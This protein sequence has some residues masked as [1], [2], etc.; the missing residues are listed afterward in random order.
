MAGTR[1]LAR[2]RAFGEWQ[3]RDTK[4]V[5]LCAALAVICGTLLV[6]Y[7]EKILVGYHAGSTKAFGDFFALWS[8]GRIAATHP[9]SD[10]YDMHL[11]HTLQVALGMPAAEQNPFPYPPTAILL[12]LP[13][14]R[15]PVPVG[16]L[17]WIG[18]T[19]ALFL[20]AV[21]ATCWRSPAIVLPLLMAPTTT[22]T[23]SGGQSG[24]LSGALLIG[25]M[26][27][28]AS[29]PVLSGILLGCLSYKPQLALLVPV[30]LVAAGL[31]RCL[32]IACV[33]AIGLAVAATILLGW[34]V[35][36]AWLAMLPAYAQMFDAKHDLLKLM[37]TVEA[38]L[39]ILGFA[40]TTAQFGQAAAALAVATVTW[41]S[42]RHGP[43]RGAVAALLVGTFLS[44]PHALIYDTPMIAG[45]LVLLV[46]PRWQARVGFSLAEVV[47]LTLAVLFP[48]LMACRV[49]TL[50]VSTPIL[51]ALLVVILADGAR[52]G[53]PRSE[54]SLAEGGSARFATPAI[55]GS[56]GR[57]PAIPM[58]RTTG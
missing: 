10:L 48:L 29:R 27:L 39:R 57:G 7:V 11:L 20:W 36:P 46:A 15:I 2:V 19:F 49:F 52:L 40:P 30:A 17:I 28:A 9:A 4:S 33:T 8:Y 32:A 37:P 6:T 54:R 18:G 21:L 47:V 24:F 38:S 45:A 5:V 43:A 58:S 42:F 23:M 41:R 22:L 14:S 31:W 13:F 1:V 56:Q 12:F 55:S 25:G 53:R 44:T 3:P 26:R 34:Q 35:W 51:L 16:Y 50:P